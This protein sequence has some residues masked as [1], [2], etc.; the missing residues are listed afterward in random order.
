MTRLAIILILSLAGS[1]GAA[2]TMIGCHKDQARIAVQALRDAKRLTLEA[3]TNLGDSPEYTRWFGAYSRP[4]AEK[5]RANFKSVL[6][7]IRTG[8]VAIQCD[9]LGDDGCGDDAYAWVYPG[10]PYRLHICPAFFDLPTMRDFQPAARA[11]KNGTREGTVIHEL[12]HFNRVARTDDH[13]YSRPDCERMAAENAA[14]A[15]DNADSY[16]YFAEDIA[17]FSRQLIRSKPVPTDRPD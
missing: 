3:A 10:E 2:Q 1:P 15:V 14:K 12:S 4:H 5:V 13:C 11:S 16:Q 6:R 17:Y 8:A 7:A 9:A